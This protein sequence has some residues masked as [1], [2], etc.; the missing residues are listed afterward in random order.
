MLLIWIGIFCLSL[1]VLIKAADYFTEAAE[2][3]GL[4]FK[5]SPFVIGMTIVSIGTAMPELATS[6]I[7]VFRGET[8]IAAAN[9]L[10]SNIANILLI[11][12]LASLVAGRLTIK[13]SVLSVDFPLLLSAT[14]LL[15][16]VMWDKTVNLGEAIVLLIAYL[17]YGFFMIRTQKM[18]NLPPEGILP[19][20][21]LPA[22]REHRFYLIK[23]NRPFN[24]NLILLFIFSLL[25]I[26][27]GAEWCVKAI[28]Q[29]AAAFNV[30]SAV[31]TMIILAVGTYLPELAV[32]QNAIRKGKIDIAL[33]NVF[34]ANIFNSLMVI[35]L[36][37]LFQTLEV[38]E[39]TF[40][41]GLPFLIGATLLYFFASFD[42]K[43]SRFEGIMYLLIYG[44]F[45]LKL[46]ELF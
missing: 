27:F 28:I 36:P 18:S 31:A 1:F 2:K 29:L 39:K 19:G 32:S 45:I 6:F 20:E 21:D 8:T 23:K 11:V 30:S 33:G 35:G 37:G 22:T 17:V 24:F 7:G 40:S 13:K 42:K 5:I 44:F 46:L 10:G 16:I 3:I 15:I 43:I 25:A 26:Y 4:A 38:S 12:G 9:A 14:V 41:V 34:G